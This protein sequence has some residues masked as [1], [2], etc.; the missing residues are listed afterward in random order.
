[1]STLNDKQQLAQVIQKIVPQSKVLRAWS[2]Q[3]GIS[4]TM[5][6]LEI[7]DPDG[8]IRKLVVRRPSLATLQQN[9]Q[10][11]AHEF[12]LLQTL[13]ALG[14]ATPTAYHLDE[15]GT[16]FPQPYLVI[17]YV[18]GQPEFAPVDVTKYTHQFANHL[19]KTHQVDGVQPALAFLPRQGKN[20]VDIVP[21]PLTQHS[22]P[23]DPTLEEATIRAT[24]QAHW[25]T[26]HWNA[27][28][29]LHGDFWPGNVLWQ[30][31]DLIA[32]IDW[33]DAKVGEPL[34]DFAISRLDILCL[35]GSDAMH[36]FSQHYQSRLMIDSTN[37]PYW[38]LYAALRLLRMANAN[39]AEWAAFFPPF[40]RP[41]LTEQSLR[42]HYHFFITQ[43]FA[44]LE[45]V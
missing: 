22:T 11:A 2:L 45:G 9:P 39:F 27:P 18:E 15:S 43:A 20:F 13:H 23:L 4:A 32:V 29:L 8:Q 6:A 25:P 30:G 34:S 1:M 44:K 42:D 40:G 37:L 12:T 28:T 21:D 38:D 10:A 7:A 16:I 3:G 41:D 5:T 26:T 24:L 14:L 17:D 33:E 19:A 36:S 31:E 35:F